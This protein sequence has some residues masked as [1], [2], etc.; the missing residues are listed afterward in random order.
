MKTEQKTLDDILSILENANSNIIKN[1]NYSCGL[2]YVEKSKDEDRAVGFFESPDAQNGELYYALI[3]AKGRRSKHEADY[4]WR[5]RIG[6]YFIGYTE[7]DISVFHK[8]YARV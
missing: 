3:E 2:E 7:G 6:D 5:V 8:R 4:Y 1:H